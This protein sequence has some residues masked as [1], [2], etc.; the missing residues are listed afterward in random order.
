MTTKSITLT[1]L[2][3][4][5]AHMPIRGTPIEIQVDAPR[6]NPPAGISF[7]PLFSP[8]DRA[9]TE[10]GVHVQAQGF[11]GPQTD[12][13]I[14]GSPFSSAGFSI[15]G[16]PLS[17]P[18][19]EHFHADLPIPASWISSLS[20]ETGMESFRR[21]HGHLSGTI[22]MDLAEP[23]P[24]RFLSL[25]GGD[26][27]RIGLGAD[28][29]FV[30]PPGEGRQRA[31]APFAYWDRR[32][33]TDGQPDNFLERWASGVMVT[34]V[35][36]NTFQ[37]FDAL[38]VWSDRSFGARG[39]YGAPPTFP[40][41]ERVQT[42]LTLAGWT[43]FDDQTPAR[44]FVGWTR[45]RDRYRLDRDDPTLYENRHRT[46]TPAFHADVAPRLTDRW[47]LWLR[48]DATLEI[49]RSDYTG[50][51]PSSGLGHH[52]RSRWSGAAIPEYT[53][54]PWQFSAGGS[55]AL[56]EKDR[57][58]FHPALGI[59]RNWNRR[60]QIFASWT[61]AARQPS[62]TELNYESPGS[63]G[64]RNLKRQENLLW[65]GGYRLRLEEGLIRFTLFCEDSRRTVD[66]IRKAPGDRWTAENL[67]DIRTLGAH[68]N[69]MLRLHPRLA[70]SAEYLALNKETETKPF[71][72]RYALDYAPHWFRTALH[73]R[74]ISPIGLTFRQ[75]LGRYQDNPARQGTRTDSAAGIEAN[76]TL[77]RLNALLQAGVANIW[78]SDFQTF[79]GQPPPG[80]EWYLTAVWLF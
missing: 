12:L 57:P 77:E 11:G 53:L 56:F 44:V 42:F 27:G 36:S 15:Q 38:T 74:P 22:E 62:F 78:D 5:I 14:R 67:G 3:A 34:D 59:A 43:R 45:H 65:E 61:G 25:Q 49:I 20:L 7:S 29:A 55:A 35:S 51:I 16:L 76:L 1:F 31:W 69:G 39:F 66:W 79:P 48:T 10:P 2:L 54:G 23:E 73:W 71:A 21:T 19:T 68:V 58:A 80:R 33:R 70:L 30:Y 47:R 40:A 50:R 28:L 60:H 17:N 8:L 24:R 37:R 6:W 9:A 18:Q 13:R 4:S 41:E 72:S 64:N 46:D 75:T 63:L 26:A 52:E 32:N